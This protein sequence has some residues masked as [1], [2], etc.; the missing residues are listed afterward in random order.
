M[1]LSLL[2]RLAGTGR[3]GKSSGL[4]SP[5]ESCSAARGL[6]CGG[7]TAPE[8][9]HLAGDVLSD[10][11]QCP[12][13]TGYSSFKCVSQVWF[14]GVVAELELAGVSGDVRESSGQ[15]LGMLRSPERV[16]LLV[17]GILVTQNI[18]GD[19]MLHFY[20]H[21]TLTVKHEL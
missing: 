1:V 16:L 12:S 13:V 17:L 9:S 11:L 14:R 15:L 20:A 2:G 19:L 7:E 8:Q 18:S 4:L 5:L 21:Q 3:L 6:R 10:S